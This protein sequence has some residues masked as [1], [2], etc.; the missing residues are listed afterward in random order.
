MSTLCTVIL[1]RF[2][3]LIEE[4]TGSSN[5]TVCIMLITLNTAYEDLVYS[6]DNLNMYIIE[7]R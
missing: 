5:E 7:I 3:L 6:L 1:K 4:V 2:T